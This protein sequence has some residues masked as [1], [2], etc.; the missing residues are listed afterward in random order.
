MKPREFHIA[1]VYNYVNGILKQVT[2]NVIEN[3]TKDDLDNNGIHVIEY[4]A[5]EELKRSYEL[6]E[7]LKNKPEQV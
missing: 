4:S 6:L 7:K 3:P 1:W 5:Y 2:T